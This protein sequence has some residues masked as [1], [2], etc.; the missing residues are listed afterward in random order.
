METIKAHG[1]AQRILNEVRYGDALLA[2]VYSS[3]RPFLVE[4]FGSA[5][6]E[7]Y[8]DYLRVLPPPNPN[9]ARRTGE[10][11]HHY[12]PPKGVHRGWRE[13][14]DRYGFEWALLSPDSQLGQLLRRSPGW[15]LE[16]EEKGSLLFR[17][18]AEGTEAPFRDGEAP[19]VDAEVWTDRGI[20]ALEIGNPFRALWYFRKPASQ[21]DPVALLGTARALM[22]MGRKDQAL[23]ALNK[24]READP[25]GTMAVEIGALEG[26]ILSVNY[27]EGKGP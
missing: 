3:F 11:A 23:R 24:A 22:A 6:P 16:V 14:L 25:E 8:G 10:T 4:E 5:S 20:E 13:V 12:Y 9:W 27:P 7:V 15:R 1:P 26:R 18:G 2:T 17:R 19:A 21:G